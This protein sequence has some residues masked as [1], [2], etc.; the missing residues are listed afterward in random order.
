MQ[1]ID[2]I[3]RKVYMPLVQQYERTDPDERVI[4]NTIIEICRLNGTDQEEIKTILKNVLLLVVGLYYKHR[5]IDDWGKN[6][7]SLE[8]SKLEGLLGEIKE[9]LNFD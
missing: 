2:K 7:W 6:F 1:S 3:E 4:S 9:A 8:P 5:A